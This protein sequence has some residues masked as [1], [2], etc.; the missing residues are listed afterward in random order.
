MH[1]NQSHFRKICKNK[2]VRLNKYHK[3]TTKYETMERFYLSKGCEL[4]QSSFS[5]AV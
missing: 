2:Y 3:M 5:V 4:V 1:P